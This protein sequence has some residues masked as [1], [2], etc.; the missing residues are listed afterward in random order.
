MENKKGYKDYDSSN[1]FHSTQPTLF[2]FSVEIDTK[3]CI[4]VHEK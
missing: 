1:N 3:A 2:A 4:I